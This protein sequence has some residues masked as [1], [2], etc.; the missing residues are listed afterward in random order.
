MSAGNDELDS[1]LS[2]MFDD[3]L[4]AAE[5]ELLARRLARDEALKARWGRYAAIG[6][7]MRTERG[8]SLNSTLSLR[9]STAIQA[10]PA[11]LVGTAGAGPRTSG[12]SVRRWWQP[13]AGVAVAASV[14]ALAVLWMRQ[15][16]PP[17]AP[18]IVQSADTARTPIPASLSTR[19]LEP[20]SYVVPTAA[21][22]SAPI[23]PPA[24][25]ANYV[26]AHSEFSAPIVRHNLLS[27]LVAAEASTIGQAA[28]EGAKARSVKHAQPPP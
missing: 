24:V 18:L 25:L 13:V 14:A 4:P 10:E 11:L 20:D 2:A 15:Q 6:A 9:V 12:S 1:Q 23:V 27:A 21:T 22:E 28:A 5:C 19:V 3:E 16:A 17:D 26:V 7:A 8:L